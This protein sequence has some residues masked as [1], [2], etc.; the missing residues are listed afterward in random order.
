MT[1]KQEPI[2]DFPVSQENR[3]V[4][5]RIERLK[6]AIGRGGGNLEV[7]RNAGVPL[8]SLNNYVAGREMKA[9]TAIRV[10]RA[11]GVSMEWLITGIGDIS[12]KIS[13]APSGSGG[14]SLSEND[15]ISIPKYD[16]SFSA[17]YGVI[18][19]NNMQPI[20]YNILKASLPP[21]LVSIQKDLISVTA[22]G[23]SMVPLIADGDTIIVDTRR[24]PI[25]NGFVYCIRLGDQLLVKRLALRVNGNL[26]IMSD[27]PRYETEEIDAKKASQLSEDGDG[28]CHILGRV[29]W[30]IG[31]VS[32]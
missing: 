13:N 10:A 24:Q 15:L 21:E 16:V 23:D 26:A 31:E 11:C 17:G 22:N 25:R 6:E 12:G 9:S 1:P 3:E 30:R 7:A 29:V 18:F 28:P 32:C 5:S 14:I 20:S 2:S 4:E 27:N 8:S 19:D